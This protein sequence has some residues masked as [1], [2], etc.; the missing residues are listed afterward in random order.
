MHLTKGVYFT[1]PEKKVYLFDEYEDAYLAKITD[2][3]N[4]CER[5]A[6]SADMTICI[7]NADGYF[8]IPFILKSLDALLLSPP[9][10]MT[11]TRFIG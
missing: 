7:E 5:A 9:F 8:S 4:R 2:F 3:R 10:G 1:L 6:G 11:L